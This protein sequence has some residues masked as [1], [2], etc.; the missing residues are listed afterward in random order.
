MGWWEEGGNPLQTVPLR[1]CLRLFVDFLKDSK[2]SNSCDQIV[3]IGHFDTHILLRTL[4]NNS[5][6]LV[7]R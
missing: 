2:R 4:Q 7:Q 6:E 3:L 1:E 5:P